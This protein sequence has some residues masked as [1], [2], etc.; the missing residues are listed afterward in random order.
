M[1]AFGALGA[2]LDAA[3]LA[4]GLLVYVL[5]GKTPGIAYQAF[6]RLFCRTGGRSNDALSSVI[7]RLDGGPSLPPPRGELGIAGDD[8]K[9]VAERLRADG[10]FVFPG[11]LP[12]AACD[13]LLKAALDTPAQIRAAQGQAPA[14]RARYDRARPAAVRYDFDAADVLA[15]EDTQALLM[16]PALLSVAREYL[17]TTPIADVVTMWWHTAYSDRPDEEAGQLYHFDMDRI[18]WLKFFVY[19]TDVGADNG[20]HCFVRG[21][22]RTDGIPRELLAKGY[23]RLSDEEVLRRYPSEDVRQVLAPHGTIIAED[24]RGLHK[25][26]PV[27]KGDRLMLQ[28]QFS[29]SLFGG[30]YPRTRLRAVRPE[31][32]AMARA[33]PKIYSNYLG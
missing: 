11:R 8:A 22:H 24:S 32:A 1:T 16:N 5:S 17:G 2:L 13:R 7:R 23:A 28:I 18:Q 10:Y 14:A 19:L 4:F 25:G 33:H 3:C 21:S 29:N 27:R 30:W 26:L 6:V 12:E 15:L 9:G 20:P 31:L